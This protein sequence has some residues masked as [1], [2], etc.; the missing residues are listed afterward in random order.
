MVSFAEDKQKIQYRREFYVL[1][2]LFIC[3]GTVPEP[4]AKQLA[5][6]KYPQPRS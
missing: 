1:S 5:R 3:E 2:Y 6:I 4:H